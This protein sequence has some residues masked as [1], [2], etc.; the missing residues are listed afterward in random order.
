M[1]SSAT[2]FFIKTFLIKK[3]LSFFLLLCQ[4]Q[5]ER[6]VGQLYSFWVERTL[7]WIPNR[8]DNL[9]YNLLVTAFVEKNPRGVVTF[10]RKP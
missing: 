6:V 1:F 8:P 5:L 9:C 7:V 4:A 10:W 3:N 2:F